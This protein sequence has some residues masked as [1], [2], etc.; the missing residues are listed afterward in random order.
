LPRER[1][2]MSQE[3]MRR[4]IGRMSHEIVE[5]NRGADRVILMG[6]QRR[7]VPIAQRIAAAI[8]AFEKIDVPVGTLDINLYRDDLTSR[9]QSRV[10]PTDLPVSVEGLVVVLV[11]DV[12][13]TGRTTRAAL[14]ALMDLG[15]PRQVQLAVMVDRGHRELPI[16]ADYV[17]KNVPTALNEEVQVRVTEFDEIEEVVLIEHEDEVLP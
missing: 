10:R 7:G 4:V 17:G 14:N 16:R 5:R 1:Q 15:R 9:P 8:G 13:Y 3:D 12:F 6:L 2:L 11:D